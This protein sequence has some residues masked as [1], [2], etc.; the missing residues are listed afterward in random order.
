MKQTN[1]NNR[2]ASADADQAGRAS[3]GASKLSP[4][5][6]DHPSRKGGFA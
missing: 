4:P 1:Q 2:G 5:S 6:G 3:H